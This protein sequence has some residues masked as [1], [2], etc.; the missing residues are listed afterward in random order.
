MATKNSVH[1]PAMIRYLWEHFIVLGHI[2]LW[3]QNEREF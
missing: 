3:G 1:V 2:V